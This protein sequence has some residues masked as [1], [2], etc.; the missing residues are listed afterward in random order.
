MRASIIAPLLLSA[1]ILVGA[2]GDNVGARCATDR[3]CSGHQYCCREGKCGG[4]MCTYAC[5]DDRGCPTDM[6]CR[7]SKCFFMCQTDRD[8]ELGFE[9]KEKDGRL[10][11]VGD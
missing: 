8:C 6:V 2:C 7:D 10:M 9:C 11:C 5:S 4:G 1:A 3:D